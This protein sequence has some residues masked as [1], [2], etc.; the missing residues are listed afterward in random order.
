MITI[1]N[2]M[3]EVDMRISEPFFI[4]KLIMILVKQMILTRDSNHQ[5]IMFQCGAFGKKN[6]GMSEN[7][8]V[9]KKIIIFMTQAAQ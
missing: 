9:L 7:M 4:T 5:M 8:F 3:K 1:E 6:P 2:E